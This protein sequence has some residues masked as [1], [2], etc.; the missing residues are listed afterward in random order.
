MSEK[1]R[2]RVHRQRH[3]AA[4]AACDLKRPMEEGAAAPRQQVNTFARTKCVMLCASAPVLANDGLEPVD[5]YAHAVWAAAAVPRPTTLTYPAVNGEVCRLGQ[6]KAVVETAMIRTGKGY[7]E[8]ASFLRDQRSA[9]GGGGIHTSVVMRPPL[10][11][12]GMGQEVSHRRRLSNRL[13]RSMRGTTAKKKKETRPFWMEHTS[14]TRKAREKYNATRRFA[15]RGTYSPR[16][17]CWHHQ[18]ND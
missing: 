13:Q 8:L 7:H 18:V 17:T 5:V 6:V 3:S 9:R 4:A 14:C 10:S 12:G 1:Q 15:S 11:V 16:V 2:Y